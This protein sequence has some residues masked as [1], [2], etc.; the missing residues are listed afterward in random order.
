MQSLLAS[1]EWLAAQGDLEQAYRNAM[2][3][4]HLAEKSQ[5]TFGPLDREPGEVG[6]SVWNQVQIQ[7]GAAAV[8][9]LNLPKPRLPS[10][11]GRRPVPSDAFPGRDAGNWQQTAGAT[12]AI[13]ADGSLPVIALRGHQPRTRGCLL[14]VRCPRPLRPP[15]QRNSIT[16]PPPRLLRIR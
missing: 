12:S 11:A 7:R 2:L 1:A 5:L 6:Q 8:A 4:Q 9:E 10:G 13:A 3:A 16:S 14:R 15:H